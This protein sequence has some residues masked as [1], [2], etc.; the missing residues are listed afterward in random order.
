MTNRYN[1]AVLSGMYIYIYMYNL[2]SM[3]NKKT[4]NRTDDNS[5]HE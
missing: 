4:K 5:K 1:S 3:M 2:S